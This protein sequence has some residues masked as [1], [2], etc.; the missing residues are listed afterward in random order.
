MCSYLTDG[1][2][3]R[4]ES[5]I[6]QA[7]RLSGSESAAHCIGIHGLV[8]D[9]LYFRHDRFHV[10]TDACNQPLSPDRD[11]DCGEIAWMLADDLIC[12]RALTCD[13]ERIVG[14]V[15]GRDA[16][17]PRMPIAVDLGFGIDASGEA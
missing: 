8:A 12:N 7:D 13:D 9:H 16:R 1:H 4:K 17:F 2:A 5:G 14:W 3:V 11:K 10:C 6:V 15:D